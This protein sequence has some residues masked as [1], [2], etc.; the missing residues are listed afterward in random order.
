LEL[1]ASLND[2]PIVAASGPRKVAAITPD[3]PG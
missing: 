1:S 2:V 3:R